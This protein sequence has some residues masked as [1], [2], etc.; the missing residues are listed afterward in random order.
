M[1]RKMCIRDSLSIVQ[2]VLLLV[3]GGSAQDAAIS[4]VSIRRNVSRTSIFAW[5]GKVG[6]EPKPQWL[7]LL[8]DSHKGVGRK[9]DIDKRLW[10]YYE[11][12]CCL[13]YTSRCV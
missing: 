8:L 5:L 4:Q 7:Q 6:G 2:E 1:K 11:S 12:W 9:A 3:D 13:L 10:S